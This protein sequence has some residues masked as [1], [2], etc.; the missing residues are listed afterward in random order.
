MNRLIRLLLIIFVSAFS[1]TL[2]QQYAEEPYS[3][4]MSY[5]LFGGLGLNLHHG[6]FKGL[7]GI[8]SCCPEF[9]SGTG[10]GPYG[11]LFVSIPLERKLDLSL[12][13]TYTD[14]SGKFST[15]ESEYLSTTN[16]S[17]TPGTFNHT[18]NLYFSSIGLQSRVEYKMTDQWRINGGLRLGSIMTKKYDQIEQ[19]S[20]PSNGVFTDTKTRTRNANQGTVTEA[21]SIEAALLVGTSYDMPLNTAYTFFLV[22]EVNL[23]YSLTPY[24]KDVTWSTLTLSAG[25]GLRYSPRIIIPPKAKTPPP[26]PPPPPPL[27]PPP[28]PAVVPSLDAD[29]L[30]VALDP[31]TDKESAI[32]N[33]VVEEFLQN[34]THPLLNYVFFDEGSSEIA[35]RYT[36]LSDKEKSEFSFKQFYQQKTMDVYYQVLNIVG[37]RMQ[38]YPQAEIKLI[39]CNSDQSVEKGNKKLSQQ[40]AEAI[41]NYLVKE[42]EIPES[43]IKIESKNL[44][45]LPSNLTDPDGIVENRRVEI[46]PNVSQIFEP[47]IIND[48][49][50]VS[51]PPHIRFKPNIRSVIGIKEWKIV[52]SQKDKDLRIFS[53]TGNI[54]KAI[55]WDVEKEDEQEFVPRMEQPL[56][57]RMIVIDNDNKSWDSP[58]QTL[59]VK[60]QTISKKIEEMIEDKE[61]NKFSMIGFGFN[62]A[63]VMGTNKDIANTAKQ[64]IRKGS[65]V[66]IIGYSDRLG[67]EELN[68]KL[69]QRRAEEVA[70]ELGIDKVKAISYGKKLLLYN[71]DLPEGRFYSRTVQIEIVTPIQ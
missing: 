49:I 5:G 54:P 62:K 41:K 20:N 14:L 65:T 46:I 38:V 56:Q 43:R 4:R 70:K 24:I 61:I 21:S 32:S 30:A 28:P 15:D 48:T 19:I 33:F 51:N 47:M 25:V 16:G 67:S 39:G 53:G 10:I 7:P 64:R 31:K 2:A 42:W 34:R 35:S 58:K 3:S 60:Q 12:R 40:R 18:I 66:N 55:D 8:P 6:A 11:G 13:V 45:D 71:N 37:K 69:S 22:P 59:E 52:T 17:G 1:Q 57:Y 68:L 29:I 44:P 27:P 9:S 23:S 63:E 36:R 26:P 50:R